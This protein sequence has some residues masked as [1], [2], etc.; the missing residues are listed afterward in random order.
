MGLVTVEIEKLSNQCFVAMPFKP[1]FDVEYEQVIKPA[2]K[3]TGLEPIRGDEI[4]SNQSIIQDIWT[5]IR[6]ARV[7]LAELSGRNPNVMYEVGLAHAI[8]KPIIILTRNEDDIP[9]DLRSLRYVYYEVSNPF[10]GDNLR[11]KI[12]DMLDKIIE[13][14]QLAAHLNGIS[15]E[16]KRLPEP[17]VESKDV[18]KPTHSDFGGL[19]TTEWLSIKKERKHKAMLTIPKNHDE[20]FLCSLMVTYHRNGVQT[21]VDEVMAATVNQRRLSLKGVSYSYVSRGNSVRYGL[22]NFELELSEKEK[23]MRGTAILSHG[24]RS[25]EFLSVHP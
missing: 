3:Q 21:I 20:K 22:D 19:W 10:W 18:I 9:F 16:F 25:V 13:N 5:H 1:L 23:I 24:K 4:Y 6:N 15:A 14:D 7:V 11:S 17:I 2:I 8:G 12:E